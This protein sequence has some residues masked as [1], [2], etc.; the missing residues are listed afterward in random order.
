VN[1]ELLDRFRRVDTTAIC[2]ADRTVR[3]VHS[4]IRP[5]STATGI[6][7]RAFTVRCREDFLAVLRAVET[8]EP[9]DVIV[10]DGGGRETALGGE[11]F[12]RTAL[13]RSLGGIVVDGGY[14]DM[15]YVATCALPVYSRFVTP[16][17]G[18]AVQPGELQVPVTCGGV[19]VNPGDLVLADDEGLVVLDPDRVDALLDAALAVKNREQKVVELLNGG[20]PLSEALKVVQ[21]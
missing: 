19:V 16:R 4:A 20:T 5:R 6:F 1:Q 9:G 8:A 12:A 2:D 11:L 15:S 7:G 17:A 14:R 13:A 18:T 10:V 3:V 21:D